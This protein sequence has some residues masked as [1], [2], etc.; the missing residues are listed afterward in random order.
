MTS[1]VVED[2]MRTDGVLICEPGDH[3][4][5]VARASGSEPRSGAAAAHASRRVVAAGSRGRAAAG[6]GCGA[7]DY[8]NPRQIQGAD[9]VPFP[10]PDPGRSACR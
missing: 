1:F 8:P 2:A 10:R 5:E 7:H 3:I 6:A 4:V 9:S